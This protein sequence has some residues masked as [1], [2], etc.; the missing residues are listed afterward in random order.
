MALALCCTVEHA[1]QCKLA[2]D[3]FAGARGRRH[4]G[5]VIGVVQCTEALRLDG[6]EALQAPAQC[7]HGRVAGVGGRTAIAQCTT[8]HCVWVESKHCRPLRRVF[9]SSDVMQ[10]TQTLRMDGVGALKAHAQDIHS[11]VEE[12]WQT[13][14]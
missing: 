3:G 2:A 7:L 1:Q 10:C 11:R 6:V 5:I 12:V 13:K 4:Q 9:G 14:R 8:Q